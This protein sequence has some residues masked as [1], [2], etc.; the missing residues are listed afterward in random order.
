MPHNLSKS[1]QI[2]TLY[3]APE[4]NMPHNPSEENLSSVA[5]IPLFSWDYRY[6]LHKLDLY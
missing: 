4:S 6:S 1:T 2:Q 3:S 5:P